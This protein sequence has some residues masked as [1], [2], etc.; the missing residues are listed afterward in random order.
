MAEKKDDN[1]HDIVVFPFHP[2]DEF[3]QQQR[4]TVFW[5]EL[6]L[7]SNIQASA[8]KVK[9]AVSTV[10]YWQSND[11]AFAAAMMQALEQGYTALE[12]DMLARMR[13]GVERRI[14][15]HGELKETVRDFD[16][17][18]A[19]RL[20]TVHKQTVA[21]TRAAQAQFIEETKETKPADTLEE[22]LMRISRRLKQRRAGRPEDGPTGEEAEQPN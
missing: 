20:L 11:P 1:T 16:H 14:Y 4:E 9:L 15:Y 13:E 21:L 12:M 3:K 19:I 6:A 7:T 8:Q 18:N 22:K 2:R 5:E 10:Y 17:K